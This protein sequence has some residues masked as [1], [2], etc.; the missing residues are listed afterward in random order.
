MTE[1]QELTLSD[2]RECYERWRTSKKSGNK[3]PHELWGLARTLVRRYS[4]SQIRDTLRINSTQYRRYILQ[5]PVESSKPKQQSF[6][7][8]SL[9]QVL[10]TVSA[11]AQPYMSIN[12]QDGT[13][14]TI[15]NLPVEQ[16]GALVN[17]LLERSSCYK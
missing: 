17:Q 16:I 3:I 12:C 4:P 5:Q 15:K 2:V 7:G 1:Q 9:N 13:A 11:N 14:L 10:S 6:V 8:T